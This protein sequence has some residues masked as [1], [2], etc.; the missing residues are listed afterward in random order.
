MARILIHTFG[1]YGDLHPYLAIA[2]ELR[3]RGHHVTIATCPIY[4]DK[5]RAEGLHFLPARPDIPLE[6]TAFIQKIFDAKRGGEQVIR[7]VT[8]PIRETCHDLL[9][10]VQETDL[11]VTHPTSCAAV[12]LAEQFRKPWVSTVLAPFSFF[13]EIDP[14]VIPNAPWLIKLRRLGPAPMRWVFHLGRSQ[15]RA[16]VQPVLDLRRELGLSAAHPLFEGQH[17]PQMVLAL[18]SRAMATPQSDWPSQA[19]VTGFPFFDR[20]HE[21]PDR[22]PALETFLGAGPPPIVFT[23]GSSA[24][25]VAGDFYRESLAAVERLRV[26]ALFLTGPFVQDLPAQL[27]PGVLATQYAPHSAVFPRASVIVHQ[28]GVG[29]TG[30]AMRSGRPSLIVPFGFDQFDNAERL[31]RLGMA[32]V[33]PRTRYNAARAESKL[34]GLLANRGVEDTAQRIGIEVRA[35]RGALEA[36]DAIEN[37]LDLSAAS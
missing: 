30:Q 33:L 31:R 18:F 21:Q 27:P 17:S 26:R 9:Q 11:I 36:A 5:I 29:T 12:A 14:P 15:S 1:S 7:Y 35:E 34:A 32:E 2:L 20:H 22:D 19:Q 16:W 10:A 13:S 8:A 37:A 4:A 24:V 3:Q 28:G 6:D 25:S 23:L